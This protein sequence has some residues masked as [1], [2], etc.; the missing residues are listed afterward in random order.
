MSAPETHAMTRHI[1]STSLSPRAR[2]PLMSPAMPPFD[3]ADVRHAT[4]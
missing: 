2:S 4:P 3:A 1:A